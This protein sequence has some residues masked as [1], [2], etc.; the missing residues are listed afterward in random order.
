[1]AHCALLTLVGSHNALRSL[2]RFHMSIWCHTRCVYWAADNS[3]G[4]YT[5][6]PDLERPGLHFVK[7]S[8]ISFTI[9]LY[10]VSVCCHI[11]GTSLKSVVEEV[12]CLWWWL[13]TILWCW[14]MFSFLFFS[15]VFLN[16]LI[17]DCVKMG[18]FQIYG[19]LKSSIVYV[20]GTTVDTHGQNGWY[21]YVPTSCTTEIT[22]I[23]WNWQ[24]Q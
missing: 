15:W 8:T 11:P 21:S 23:T 22:D 7:H 5:V 10:I 2:K 17:I 1:M 19:S 6:T 3:D 4:W 9:I 12:R 14:G 18:T 13:K 20:D 24:K 16:V